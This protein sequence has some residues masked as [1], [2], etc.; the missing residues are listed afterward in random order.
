MDGRLVEGEGR[1]G[2]RVLVLS[3]PAGAGHTRAAEAIRASASAVPGIAEVIHLDATA[4]ATPRLRQVYAD[5]YIMLALPG[6]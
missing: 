4:Y 3:V 1:T 5:L 2:K 6:P